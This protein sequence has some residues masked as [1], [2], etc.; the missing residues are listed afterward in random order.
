MADPKFTVADLFCGAGGLSLGLSDAGLVTVFAADWDDA[1]VETYR[2]N[3]GDHVQKCDL[4][5]GPR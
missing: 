5:N 4:S 1:A 3:L 2:L